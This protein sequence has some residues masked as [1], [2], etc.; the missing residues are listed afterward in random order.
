MGFRTTKSFW[1]IKVSTYSLSSTRAAVA[2]R[3]IYYQYR[4]VRFCDGCGSS[5]GT[6][7]N[8]SRN[9]LASKT[10]D[11]SERIY[12]TTR[13][14]LAAVIYALKEFRHYV[15][16][17]K[18]VLLKTDHGASTSLFKVPVP[19]H[20]QAWY[21][22]FLADYNFEIQH[23]AGSQHG[24]SDGISRRPCGSKKCTREDWSRVPTNWQ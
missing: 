7:R 3:R 2:W 21:L 14:E 20:Q 24:N 10:V 18:L 17:G 8:R 9:S 16:G 19:I 23:R 1:V 12:C 6:V 13:K 5:T 22:S 15:F 11:A 4:R